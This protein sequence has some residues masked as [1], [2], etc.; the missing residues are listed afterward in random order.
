MDMVVI[1]SI[2]TT[3]RVAVEDKEVGQGLFLRSLR[4]IMDFI[5]MP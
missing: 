2:K 4:Y 1:I 5:S 3:I